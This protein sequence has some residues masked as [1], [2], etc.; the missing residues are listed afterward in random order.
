MFDL[1]RHVPLESVM[2]V[3]PISMPIFMNFIMNFT[4]FFF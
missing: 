2:E 3:T 4:L 1:S